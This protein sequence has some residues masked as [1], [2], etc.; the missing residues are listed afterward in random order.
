MIDYEK[1]DMDKYSNGSDSDNMN[2]ID[3]QSYENE[4]S[5]MNR[6]L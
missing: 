1:D 6:N 5:L 4:D 2:K 3:I